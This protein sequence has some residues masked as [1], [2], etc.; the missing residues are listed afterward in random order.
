MS[1]IG[2]GGLLAI[3]FIVLKILHKISWSWWWVL[4]PLWVGAA[5]TVVIVALF[6]GGAGA[7]FA[8]KRRRR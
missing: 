1:G 5:I 8:L 3:V 6:L 7:V 2:F 4:S